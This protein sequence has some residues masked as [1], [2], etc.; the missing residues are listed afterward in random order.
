MTYAIA[1]SGGA[2]SFAVYIMVQVVATL[3]ATDQQVEAV[4]AAAPVPELALEEVVVPPPVVIGVPGV[5][6][7]LFLTCVLAS[8]RVNFIT[9]QAVKEVLKNGVQPGLKPAKA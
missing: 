1:R 5:C 6:M 3:T 2:A 8:T 7:Y 4:P 9:I